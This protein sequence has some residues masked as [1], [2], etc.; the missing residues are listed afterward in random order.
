LLAQSVLSQLGRSVRAH[1]EYEC[2]NAEAPEPEALGRCLRDA[3]AAVDALEVRLGSLQACA[4]LPLDAFVAVRD[5]DL[6][7][8][9]GGWLGGGW[10]GVSRGVV[11][12]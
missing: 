12:A 1:A 8:L 5:V 9:A 10:G 7:A 2:G 6:G 11:L 4:A 3:L